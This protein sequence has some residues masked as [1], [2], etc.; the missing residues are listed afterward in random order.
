MSAFGASEM[1]ALADLLCPDTADDAYFAQQQEQLLQQQQQQ[2]QQQQKATEKYK[3]KA[4]PNFKVKT[5]VGGVDEFEIWKESD[6]TEGA[7]F[8]QL[9]D[10]REE[11]KYEVL[12]SQNVGAEDVYLGLGDKD[13]TTDH[14]ETLLIK[15]LEDR[16]VVDT[17]RYRLNLPLP[18]PVE[19]EKGNCK[20]LAPTNCLTLRLPIKRK[21]EYVQI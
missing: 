16:I 5:K 4:K 7:T 9:K 11:P 13:P 14:C 18:Y 3:S 15:T 6:L 17:P 19:V 12:F 10:S 1:Q 20:W 21:I 8:R 2:Q